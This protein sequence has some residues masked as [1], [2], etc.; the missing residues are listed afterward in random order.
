MTN[1]CE[2]SQ[3]DRFWK[4][5]IWSLE[6]GNYFLKIIH[7]SKLHISQFEICWAKHVSFRRQ[8]LV[9]Q[10][11]MSVDLSTLEQR[12]QWQVV[13]FKISSKRSPIP[14]ALPTMWRSHSSHWEVGIYI[15]FLWILG[16]VWLW[17][18]SHYVI[19]EAR[20][21]KVVKLPPVHLGCSLLNP[22]AMPCGS[23]TT[24]TA[25]SDS[26]IWGPRKQPASAVTCVWASLCDHSTFGSPIHLNMTSWEIPSKNPRTKSDNNKMITIALSHCVLGWFSM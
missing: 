23:Q 18:K 26:L 6:S 17:R 10:P 3:A 20:S 11:Y 12:E 2:Y 16:G 15:L 21:Y 25:S 9:T 19:S 5:Y 24:W 1:W 13:Y 8:L 22:T 7:A 4:K 14:H